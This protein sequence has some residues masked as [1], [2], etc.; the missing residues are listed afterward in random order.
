MYRGCCIEW[1]CLMMH[2]IK[3]V[4]FSWAPLSFSHTLL[5][6]PPL[7]SFTLSL[8]LFF[9][10][11]SLSLHLNPTRLLLTTTTTTPSLSPSPSDAGCLG[12]LATRCSV[13]RCFT[14]SITAR[15]KK[16]VW[17]EGVIK[18]KEKKERIEIRYGW[19]KMRRMKAH[20]GCRHRTGHVF[21]NLEGRTPLTFND[22]LCAM[23]VQIIPWILC[24]NTDAT[25]LQ[26]WL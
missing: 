22:L 11:F 7:L 25:R 21:R 23:A 6:L 10:P 18:K 24:E 15:G 9:P 2:R 12:L 19:G 8:P 17:R 26:L 16:R 4:A 14:P 13:L 5:S 1:D 20:I 3:S